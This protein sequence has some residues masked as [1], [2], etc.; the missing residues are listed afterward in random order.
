[1]KNYLPL[2]SCA[3]FAGFAASAQESPH[4]TQTPTPPPAPVVS[5]LGTLALSDEPE[6]SVNELIRRAQ[7]NS[8][9]LS[10]AGENLAAARQRAKAS[11]A[12]RSPTLQLVPGLG[13]TTEARDEEVILS[14]PLDVFGLRRARSGVATAE[15]RRAEA[16]NHLAARALIVEVKNAALALFAAQEA[17]NL[18]QVQVEVAQLFHDAAQRRAQLGD[19]PPVQVQRAELELARLQNDLAN[20]RAERVTRRALVNQLIGQPPA[21]PLRV[22]LTF[23]ASTIAF[24][25][26]RLNSPNLIPPGGAL[27]S[28]SETTTPATS[29]TVGGAAI[30]DS[31][32]TPGATRPDIL[33]AQAALA[34]RQAQ[35][36]AIR[37][38][39]L[40]TVELQARRSAF[41]GRN[42]SYAL[43]AVVTLPVF[44]FGALRGERRAM[45]AEARAQEAA[46]KLLEQQ[47]AT[48]LE[49]A[50]VRL[51]QGRQ[52]VTR[53]RDKL[54]PLTLDLLRKTQ[55]GYAQGASTYLE[56]LEAQR[57]LRQVQS[58]YL[59]ALVG[60]QAGEN[61]LEA[62]TLGGLPFENRFETRNEY[63]TN[64]GASR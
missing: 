25:R 5:S 32:Q 64:R 45:E 57:T 22:A 10:I 42:G 54:L 26:A 35:A 34:L 8:P 19:V 50:R 61:A 46:V 15:F 7:Q 16:E 2:F 11:R 58:E 6:I 49:S 59:Q 13:G 63:S 38:E 52:N 47:A 20:A 23:D 40:P 31:V 3:A 33:S 29:A 41:F 62:A 55:I 51:E 17:E 43:R 18:E 60:V 30:S 48:Q 12:L 9:R 24:L 1:M 53:Y 39:G 4:L 28:S 27:T 36:R 44:D 56:V 37:R 21:T 14:Q